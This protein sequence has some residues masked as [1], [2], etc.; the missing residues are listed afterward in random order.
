MGV[1]GVA[2]FGW[3]DDITCLTDVELRGQNDEALCLAYKTSIY[4]AVA[5]VYLRDDGYVLK[6]LGDGSYYPMPDG[7]ALIAFQADGSLPSPLPPYEL[8]VEDYFAGFAVWIIIAVFIVLGVV[9]SRFKTR[10]AE[11]VPVE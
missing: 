6:V 1:G 8:S 3:S 7:D 11:E 2:T 9:S 5:P 4:H 10:E